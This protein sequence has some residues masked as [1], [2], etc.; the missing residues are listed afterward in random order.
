MW[1]EWRA[2]VLRHT[3][4]TEELLGAGQYAIAPAAGAALVAFALVLLIFG[5][6]AAL[7]GAALGMVAGVAT[8][9]YFRDVFPWW[10]EGQRWHWV[11]LLFLLAS[12]DGLLGRAGT[13][14]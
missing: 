3:P 11:P 1:S 2:A 7:P 4:P 5:K 6:R 12:V 10:P 8:A 9:N 13:P 14:A